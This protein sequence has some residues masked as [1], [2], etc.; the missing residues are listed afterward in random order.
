[1]KAKDNSFKIIFQSS[2]LCILMGFLIMLIGGYSRPAFGITTAGMLT[3]DE[4]WSGSVTITGDVI[5][6]EGITLTI[7]PGT[8]VTLNAGLGLE[9]LID[10]TLVAEGTE[11]ANITF[12]SN[13]QLPD[14]GD[15]TW[16]RFS[17]TGEGSM[18]YCHIEYANTG[19]RLRNA[20]PV[21]SHNTFF[22]N[23]Y[24][25]SGTISSSLISD[26]TFMD[27]NFGISIENSSS[28]IKNNIFNNS[29]FDGINVHSSASDLSIYNNLIYDSNAHG[30][31]IEYNSSPIVINNTLYN[32]NKSGIYV[33]NNSSPELINNIIY[34][35]SNFGILTWDFSFPII[36]YNN[37]FDNFVAD[38]FDHDIE[39]SFS[40]TPGTGEISADPIFADVAS[41]NF[42]LKTGSPCIDAGL[43]D[44][45]PDYDMAGTGRY[46]DP[47]ILNT[48]GGLLAY[49]DIGA[50]EYYVNC[51]G[52]YDGDGDLG[53]VGSI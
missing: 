34:Y 28:V 37:V 21:I 53:W 8:Q 17:G 16:I 25:I 48:G 39:N 10:G 2:F 33:K 29:F 36:Q 7:A 38:Y 20:S 40:P 9:L 31:E 1:M 27:N 13:A 52:D 42:H 45:A 44:G 11:S 3:G 50:Y 26:N 35:S 24:G 43:S 30:I 51:P 18:N 49:Y 5:V 6:P 47:N 22:K 19:V 12:T 4:T 32:N 46:D 14:R 41:R 23:N 15:W